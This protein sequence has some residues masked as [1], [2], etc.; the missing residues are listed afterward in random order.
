MIDNKK[1][2]Y[3]SHPYRGKTG[4]IEEINDNLEK[5]NDICRELILTK[6]DV[7]V[8]SPIHN[9][10]FMNSNDDQNLILDKCTELLHLCDELWL[11]GDWINSEG[12]NYEKEIAKKLNIKVV[13]N[14]RSK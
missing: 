12:C 4:S 11:Y 13:D 8:I 2:I 10:S 1:V 7:I 3:V 6:N 9:Y 5:I 14:R